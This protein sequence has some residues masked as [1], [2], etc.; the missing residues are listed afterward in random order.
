MNFTGW[1]KQVRRGLAAFGVGWFFTS[2]VGAQY[3]APDP[4]PGEVPWYDLIELEAFVDAY[5]GVN[6]N[7]P[8]PQLGGNLYRSF[9]QTSGFALSWVGLDASLQPDPIGGT[10]SLRYGPSA[11]ILADRCLHQNRE[12]NPCDGDV[13]LQFLQ[14]AFASWA[15]GGREGVFRFDLGKF[16]SVYGVEAPE[17]QRN[18]N[19]T[20]GLLFSLAQP[21]FH[22]GLR[23]H[24]DLHR[25][26]RMNLLVVNGVNNTLDNN[27][28]KTFGA[29]AVYSPSPLINVRLGWLGGPEQDD[30]AEFECP[31]GQSYSPEAE[32][33]A[34]DPAAAA[35]RTYGVSRAG[36]NAWKAW[37]HYGDLVV[38]YRPTSEWTMILNGIIG[39]EGERTTLTSSAVEARRWY[40][41]AVYG[42]F[43]PEPTWGIGARGEYINDPQGHLTGVSEAQLV[44]GTLTTDVRIADWLQ[45]RLDNRLDTLVDAAE[46]RSVF[47]V[48]I[49]NPDGPR[50][51]RSFQ[52]TT[53]LGVIVSSG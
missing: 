7:F 26:F 50:D 15:P 47:P 22:T 21:L 11:E 45:L 34:L 32:G 1:G 19:Y 41:A 16:N 52:I 35:R 42:Y 29:Q 8:R 46:E 48:G 2:S 40:G 44:S 23:A 13:G 25:Q 18:G 10:V 30:S 20:R 53:T 38:N 4:P 37:R 49:R 33:C 43:A 39:Y 31:A 12:S 24:L 27:W 3:Y 17:A 14:Q 6:Y 28:G 9:D 36:A 5:A 51:T